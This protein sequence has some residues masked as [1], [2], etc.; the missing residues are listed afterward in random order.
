MGSSQPAGSQGTRA[1]SSNN[2]SKVG[3]L[4]QQSGVWSAVL[5]R[6]Q[7]RQLPQ[8]AHSRTP[9]LPEAPTLLTQS[10]N[11]PNAGSAFG[12]AA[13]HKTRIAAVLPPSQGLQLRRSGSRHSGARLQTAGRP[14]GSRQQPTKA[15]GVS[16]RCGFLPATLTNS[17]GSYVRTTRSAEPPAR[18]SPCQRPPQARGTRRPRSC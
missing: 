6:G 12:L 4:P 8:H 1:Q 14:A 9:Q 15:R 7:S 17:Q 10:T 5:G 3:F 13:V 16:K 2:E 18:P 11:T